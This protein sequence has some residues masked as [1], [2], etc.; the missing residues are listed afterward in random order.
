MSNSNNLRVLFYDLETSPLLAYIWRPADDYVTMDRLIHD[1]WLICWSAKW[2]HETKIHTGLVTTQEAIDQDDSRIVQELAEMIRSADI[3]VAHNGDRFDLPR[4][5]ARLLLLGQE[6]LGPVQTIDTLTLARKNFAL[7]YNKLDY[8]AEILGFGNK[9]KT[10]FALWRN[11]Y[12]GDPKALKQMSRYNVKDVVL[13]E[14]VFNK[15]KPYVKGLKRLMEPDYYNEF[16]CPFCGSDDLVKRGLV[17]SQSSTFQRYQCGGCDKYS[18][19]RVAEKPKFSV[20]P[21]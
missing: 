16:A 8:L 3:I 21:L 5:N 4:F 1:S 6:P 10:D 9:L 15:L 2:A 18:R 13:L 11:A 20:V 7:A 19:S 14:K 12:H 17:R